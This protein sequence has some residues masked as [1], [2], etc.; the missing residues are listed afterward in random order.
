[1]LIADANAVS[2][3]AL[4]AA[5]LALFGT[6]LTAIFAVRREREG[7]RA[8]WKGYKRG[9]YKGFLDSID[10][11]AKASTEDRDQRLAEYR[12]RYH[13]TILACNDGVLA[14]M[15]KLKADEPQLCDCTKPLNLSSPAVVE[16]TGAM[17]RDVRPPGRGE[18]KYR[19]KT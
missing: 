6:G 16:L 2:L 15:E 10:Q 13:Q 9:V 3:T 14:H 12:S 19:S 4:G 18:F 1:M 17:K 7:R 5:F 8:T 11:V